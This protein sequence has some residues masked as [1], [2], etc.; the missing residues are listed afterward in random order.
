[1]ARSLASSA[2]WTSSS[3][4][5]SW[6]LTPYFS[7]KASNAV[8]KHSAAAQYLLVLYNM[9]QTK[10]H[11]RLMIRVPQSSA[12]G[13]AA[14]APT[15]RPRP[16]HAGRT[17]RAAPNRLRSA[18]RAQH[19]DLRW[20]PGS[21][22]RPAPSRASVA[23][24]A[25]ARPSSSRHCCPPFANVASVAVEAML[26]VVTYPDRSGCFFPSAKPL[27]QNILLAKQNMRTNLWDRIS[28]S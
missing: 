9:L 26:V 22:T 20:T 2:C 5:S 3:S 4:S 14:C 1:M 25:C 10:T 16:R 18:S 12:A 13:S 21:R 28:I 15:A 23:G 7:H 11:E 8:Y 27:C 17:A 6:A 19:A 24:A